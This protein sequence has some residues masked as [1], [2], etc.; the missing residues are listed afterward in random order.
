MWDMAKPHTRFNFHVNTNNFAT[1]TLLS[2]RLKHVV[3]YYI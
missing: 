2:E 3:N 1:I